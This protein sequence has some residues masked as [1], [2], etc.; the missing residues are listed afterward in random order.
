MHEQV[1]EPLKP[2]VV[3]GIAAHPDDL[4]FSTPASM[5]KSTMEGVSVYYLILTDGSKGSDDRSMTSEQL[6]K[7]R[8]REQLASLRAIGGKEATFLSY[9]DSKLQVTMDLK[10]DI[11]KEIRRLKPD[12]VITNDPTFVYSARRG[13]I[14]RSDHRAAGQATIDAVFPLAGDHLTFPDRLKTGSEPHKVKTLLLTNFEY[15]NSDIDVTETV[16]KKWLALKAHQSNKGFHGNK[17]PLYG[18]SCPPL[19][20]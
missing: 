11:V 3:L 20:G 12:L 16:A 18:S 10:R 14:N 17:K 13:F 19:S 1:F 4:D 8:V 6:V 15:L 9:P 5:A 2:A 7:I